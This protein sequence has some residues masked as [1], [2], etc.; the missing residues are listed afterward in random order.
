MATRNMTMVIPLDKYNKGYNYPANYKK[1]S[2]VNMYLHHD[3][4]P[5]WQGVQLANWLKTNSFAD[6]T[7]AA[8]KMVHDHY[9]DSCYLH[10]NVDDIDHNYTYMVFVGSPFTEN[11]I[12]CYNKYSNKEVF[13]MTP[14]EVLEKYKDDLEYTNF[15][16]GETRYLQSTKEDVKYHS[17]KLLKLLQKF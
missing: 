17:N 13:D 10:D 1:Y 7:R 9:Y 14:D 2:C 11:R 3:G 8:A 5:E 6:E 15:A 16:D 4:Y 12:V